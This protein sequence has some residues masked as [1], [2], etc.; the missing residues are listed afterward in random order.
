[1]SRSC[2]S[3]LL[4]AAQLILQ[5]KRLLYRIEAGRRPP[6]EDNP[7]RIALLA[8]IAAAAACAARAPARGPGRWTLAT[9][10]TTLVLGAG[11]GQPLALH[12][13]RSPA[14]WNWTAEPSPV[15]L[16][17]RAEADGAARPLAW[18]Y[19]KT[20]EDRK[21][22]VKITVHF[23]SADPALEL[24]SSW[25][26]RRGPGPVRHAMSIRNLSGRAVTVFGPESLDLRVAGPDDATRVWYVNDDRGLPD[27]TGVYQDRP[28]EGYEKILRVSEAQDFIPFVAVD[29]GGRHGLYVGWE[30]SLGRIAIA[31][32]AAPRGVRLRAGVRDDFRTDLEAGGT[33]EVPPGFVGAHAGDLDD[34]G[35]SLRRYL[36][37]HSMPAILRDDPGYPK[38][39]WNAFAA[40]GKTQ[41]GWD[42]TEAKYRP[43]IDDIAPLG[44][45]EVV[46]DVG[47]WQGDTKNQPHPPVG[48][49]KDWPSGM[50][51][52]RDY[53]HDKGMRFGL[54]WN[55]NPPM[56][57]PE[58]IRHRHDDAKHLYDQF[59]IDFYRSDGTDGNVLQTGGHGPGT[60]ARGAEDVGY[61]QTRGFYEF[62]DSMSAAVPNF[63]YEC[64]SNGGG[65]KDYGILRRCVKIQNQDRYY[66]IDARR[67]FYD[68]SHAIHPMQIAALC[69][70]WAEW[71]AAGSVYEFRS[72]SMGAAYWH[73]D[74]PNGGN[75]GPVWTASQRT[76]VR[77]AVETYKTRLRPLI[78]T[79]NLYHVFP[80][81]D[82]KAWDGV[83]YFDPV[84]KKGAV[85]VFRPGSPDAAREIRFKGLDAKTA[86]WLW[87]EDGSI[88]P[89]RRTGESLMQA[90]LRLVLPQP[91]TSDIVFFQEES[92]GRPGGLEEP[93][94]F[95]LKPAKTSVRRLSVSAELDWEP[96]ANAR[97]YRVTVGE[98]PDLASPLA[99]ETVARPPVRIP[100]LPASRTLYWKVDAASR[101]GSRAHGGP[102][103]TFATP[104]LA[105]R[106]VA[107]ASDLPWVRAAAGA[108]NPVRRDRNLKEKPLA[109]GGNPVEKGLWTHAFNDGTPADV[110]F[111][112]RKASFAAF[113]AAVGLDDLGEKGSVQFQVLVDG[114]KK[115]ESPVLKPRKIHSL[116]VDVKGAR[117]VTLRVLNGGDGYAWDH[118]A[119]GFARFLEAGAED[120]LDE[121]R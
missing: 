81:P 110:V 83:E 17:D 57:T 77:E 22:G 109:I 31:A 30:W 88:A 120:P 67:S 25:H 58:G 103:G 95:S 68:A 61:W 112:V 26:A 53:A 69:G 98:T 10:D 14:G 86:Y 35:N 56:T 70:S 40:T 8:L 79:A 24:A 113:K 52:V 55:C 38:V 54:Y 115:A 102:A 5:D 119:W 63:S 7:T 93:G 87:C 37:N 114:E 39:E 18:V 73:P 12:E 74:A 82:D 4:R 75:G 43:L 29:S 19:R 34:G 84:S 89:A 6:R 15:P 94:A 48:D 59:L 49:A 116:S 47:W 65:L 99:F 28:V 121:R 96:G 80:R 50:R 118:A 71:Q 33:F 11:A 91:F 13:I 9:D 21:D 27:K 41:G 66:P 64:C 51:A 42:P 111:D 20:T 117:E 104:D 100:R 60:R 90:G 106:G 72:S 16:P 2:G 85:F 32:H 45:E 101:G 105:F 78:R 3:D 36:F 23:S 1:V 76:L 44:F 92:L 107:F 46:L 62:L 97:L 108:D